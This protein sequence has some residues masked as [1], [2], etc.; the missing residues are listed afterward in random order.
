MCSGLLPLLRNGSYA[1]IAGASHM[2]QF[3]Q[4][5]A[6]RDIVA[7]FVA[8]RQVAGRSIRQAMALRVGPDHD[9][10]ALALLVEAFDDDAIVQGTNL[11]ESSWKGARASRPPGGR[12][13]PARPRPR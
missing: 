1:Q 2:A 5:T 9:Q 4:P 3:D 6:W 10:D 13:R 12:V 7:A 11:H 8:R